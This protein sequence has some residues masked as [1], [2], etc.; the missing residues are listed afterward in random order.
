MKKRG[1]GSRLRALL[2]GGLASE[3]SFE[4]L[5]EALIEAD[6]GTRSA[7]EMVD[8]LRDA[9]Q[10]EAAR[11]KDALLSILRRQIESAVLPGSLELEPDTLNIILV[12]GVNGVGK[13]TTIAKLAHHFRESGHAKGICLAAGDTFRAAAIEQL[14]VH[15][16]RLGVRIVKQSTGSDSAAVIYDA[17]ESARGKGDQL[18]IA[19]T[20]GRMHTKKHL[21]EELSKVDRIVAKRAPEASYRRLLVIDATTGQNGLHQAEIFKEAVPI[22]GLVLAKYDSTAR[23]GILI[24]IAKQLGIPTLF[25]GTGESYGDLKP[26]K[27]HEYAWDLTEAS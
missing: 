10:L 6:V 5:E 20:A 26:F 7:V 19:D 27:A 21:V 2:A 24:P 16:E 3:E 15:A 18:V 11:S 17:I 23:G 9:S 1:L 8:A 12:L 13:T 25:L 4:E 22:D 14:T